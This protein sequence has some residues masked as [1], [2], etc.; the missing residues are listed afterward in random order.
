MMTDNKHVVQAAEDAWNDGDLDRAF[1]YFAPDYVERTPF[2]GLPPTK[3]GVQQLLTAFR[4][5]FPD[6]HVTVDLMMAEG[7]LVAYHSTARGTHTGAF[8]GMPATGNSVEVRA[9]HIH[10][11]KDG[12]I[13]EH[14]GQADSLG[15]MQQLG[16]V[17]AGGP[18]A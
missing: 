2:P 6:G 11:V 5:A 1:S 18:A 10:R 9:I 3:E 14:W 4:N 15:L 12:R 17:P 13:V 16:A 8:M 7:D